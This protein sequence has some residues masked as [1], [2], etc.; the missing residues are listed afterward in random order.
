MNT[1]SL[2]AILAGWFFKVSEVLFYLLLTFT[3]FAYGTV[4][5]W[6]LAVSHLL[7][8]SLLL[9]F[10]AGKIF[11]GR[12]SFSYPSILSLLVIFLLWAI[13]STVWITV[14]RYT[15]VLYL[16]R[17]IDYTLVVFY[18]Y[19]HFSL[20]ERRK[21]LFV[22]ITCIGTLVAGYGLINY[23]LPSFSFHAGLRP[24][25]GAA[26]PYV[27]HNHFAGYLELALAAAM[28]L[29]LYNFQR[30]R[31]EISLLFIVMILLMFIGLLFSLSRAGIISFLVVC[32]FFFIVMLLRRQAGLK[33]TPVV[34][35]ICTSLGYLS[36]LETE[37]VENRLKTLGDSQTILTLNGRTLAWKTAYHAIKDSPLKGYGL[38][39]FA[40]VIPAYREPGFSRRFY[41]AH[42]DYLQLW[43]EAGIAGSL[44]VLIGLVIY[45][46]KLWRYL[47]KARERM[48]YLVLGSA[49]GIMAIVLHSFIDFNLNL[50]ANALLFF[51]LAALFS[52]KNPVQGKIYGGRIP[53]WTVN[54]AVIISISSGLW[55]TIPS[56]RADLL[57]R[58]AQ[59]ISEE[60]VPFE[61]IE[62]Y[63]SAHELVPA[64]ATYLFSLAHAYVIA[65]RRGEIPYFYNRAR[66]YFDVSL[67]LNPR[68]SEVWLA[69]AFLEF[70]IEN[71]KE[72]EYFF[73]LAVYNDP[74]NPACY[75]YLSDYYLAVEDFSSAIEVSRMGIAL[76][77]SFFT[78]R[79][80]KIWRLTQ[81]IPL[82]QKLIPESFNSGHFLLAQHFYRNKRYDEVLE[83]LHLCDSE[84]RWDKAYFE[85]LGQNYLTLNK[86]DSAEYYFRLGIKEKPEYMPNYRR[87]ASLLFHQGRLSEAEQLFEKALRD[88][89]P[90]DKAPIHYEYAIYFGRKKDFK[91]QREQINKALKSQ[92]NNL[93]YLELLADSY[94]GEERYYEAL[95]ELRRV[96]QLDSNRLNALRKTAIIFE[97]TGQTQRAMDYCS[98]ILEISS[99]DRFALGMIKK[100]NRTNASAES[101]DGI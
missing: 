84:I 67:S 74:Q 44:L 5:T 16:L 83:Q 29:F 6:S 66:E 45:W 4:E 92:V 61:A 21:R 9:F 59:N 23:F 50:H 48:D 33:M 69:K 47:W 64:N 14:Y 79:L 49:G 76:A 1:Q 27:N 52:I 8:Y 77:P 55:F 88:L 12:S 68:N 100:I 22:V 2:S 78:N 97:K 82:I 56:L 37:R 3:P 41:Y 43:L 32:G 58:R 36:I 18:V 30:I 72:A 34:L 80:N 54:L 101:F 20:V 99:Q 89:R 81:D 26:A 7:V 70:E 96:E 71:N 87:L 31:L 19:N 53:S 40:A 11:S 94:L 60:S 75:F 10:L 63:R 13:I 91:S 51:I 57:E 15:S 39:T 98:K 46:K 86:A 85:L 65:A 38:G 95:R 73:Q 17:I 42:N 28:G 24:G 93:S 25:I 35:L 62:L 90:L